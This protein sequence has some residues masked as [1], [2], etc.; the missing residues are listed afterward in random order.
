MSHDGTSCQS[1]SADAPK[2][3]TKP[4]VRVDDWL[5]EHRPSSYWAA[6]RRPFPSLL[7]VAP[8]G[9]DL[10]VGGPL[11]GRSG[12]RQLRTGADTWMRHALSS[13]G[14]SDHWLLPLLLFLILL[15]WQV[16]SFYDWGFSPGILAGMVVESLVWAVVL[17][18]ISRLIDFGFSYLE[19][20]GTPLLAVECRRGR[21][22]VRFLDRLPGCRGLRGDAV[23][24]DPGSG[25]VR[26]ACDSCRC[27]R[28]WRAPW[29]SPALRCSSPWRTTR[30]ARARRSPGSRS[31]SA[32]WPASSSPGFCA[33]GIRYCRRHAH[34]V[35]HPGRLDCLATL[36]QNSRHNPARPLKKRPLRIVHVSDIHF[37]QYAINPL[38]LLSKRLLG[39][40]SLLSGTRA[41]I[42]PRASAR[43]GRARAKPEC[44]TTS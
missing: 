29:L 21:T 37:W 22:V 24:L 11:A 16:L 12:A 4:G 8:L 43:T 31:F 9:A 44:R 19:Q 23:S 18:G 36:S 3:R 40:T 6:T 7:L 39:T 14:L 25:F 28:C 33:A 26:D 15:T 27:P 13:L 34:H 42:S 17:L 38:R 32:G 5:L 1:R 35:R 2:V 41:P 20:T 30:A 10:R